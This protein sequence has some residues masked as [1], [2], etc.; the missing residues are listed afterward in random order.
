MA[1]PFTEIY[2]LLKNTESRKSHLAKKSMPTSYPKPNGQPWTHTYD[3]IIHY[4]YDII[5]TDQVIFKDMYVHTHTH[6]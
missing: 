5:H 4:T 3:I 6:M 2:G 1:V